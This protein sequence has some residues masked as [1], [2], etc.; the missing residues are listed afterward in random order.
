MFCTIPKPSI[1]CA[2]RL[3]Y[4][5]PATKTVVPEGRAKMSTARARA[6]V[7][8]ISAEGSLLDKILAEG[9]LA[10]TAEERATARQWV[11]AFVEQVVTREMVISK[12][13]EAM[14]NARI[15]AIDQALSL[16]LN[17]I[18]H[19]EAFQNLEASWRGL[20]YFV[21]QTETSPMLKIKVMNISK[22]DLLRDL[23]KVSEFDQSTTFKKVHDEG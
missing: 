10:P 4:P 16:Q 6:A 9:R 23:Q 5:S 15:A 11:E 12:D 21:F 13:T 7:Q 8:Q 20:K 1:S 14:L 19:A 3:A 17:E 22:R 2:L 18:M